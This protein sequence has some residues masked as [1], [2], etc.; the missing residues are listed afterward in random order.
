MSKGRAWTII[1]VCS[2]IVIT[3]KLLIFYG[4]RP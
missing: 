1:L 4:I 3:V 2:L